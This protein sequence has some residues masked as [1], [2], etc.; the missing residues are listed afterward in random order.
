MPWRWWRKARTAGDQLRRHAA[1]A[2]PAHLV[3]VPAII[4]DHLSA[5]IRDMLRDGGQEVGGGEDLEVAVDLG[6][7]QILGYLRSSRV[8]N[9]LLINLNS[10][11]D[12]TAKNAKSAKKDRYCQD[13]SSVGLIAN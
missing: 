5:F 1:L 12:L 2:D 10:T 6:V 7:D 4:S 13:R 11:V 8:E 9:G 3:A